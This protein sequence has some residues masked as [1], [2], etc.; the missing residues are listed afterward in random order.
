MGRAS[1]RDHLLIY[2]VA[3]RGEVDLGGDT[4][5]V[6]PGD[7]L[8]F[9][10][11]QPHRYRARPDD[12]W[13]IYWV[14]LGGAAVDLFFDAIEP[15]PR[16]GLV[17][18]GLHSRLSEE[19]EVLLATAVSFQIH[20][21]VHAANV[22]RGLLTFLA[23]VRRRQQA[24]QAALDV[25]RVQ[26]YLQSRL[27]ERLAL[28]DLVADTMGLLDALGIERA[29]LVG[30]SMGG[31]VAQLAAATH[32]ERVLS[33]T[34]I[35]S[36]TNSPFL[37]P[38]KPAALKTLVAPRVKIETVEDYVAFGLGMMAKLGGT[39]DQGREELTEM[40]QRS[41]ER[42]LNPRGIRNQFMAIM[43]TGNLSKRLK[44]VR[45]PAQVIHGGSDPLIRPA[46][47]RASARAM[48]GARLAIIDGMGHDF[49]PSV[50]PRLIELVAE[51]C[52]R[53]GRTAK[54]AA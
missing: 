30:A 31:M 5:P 43:A 33:V 12:P 32:P 24:R 34:S 40:F 23:L 11:G 7:V 22:L 6:G 15:D 36:S 16:A 3:G 51:N 47:G 46:G 10:E 53:A 18:V 49:P 48:P 25:D 37:P 1:P 14:H 44:K 54:A 38:P 45:C 41:W 35:M 52:A 50:Q 13:T 4:H 21:Q 39:L 29:H 26:S 9:R 27:H 28:D 8:L 17:P 19:F 42:G 2:C 20:H